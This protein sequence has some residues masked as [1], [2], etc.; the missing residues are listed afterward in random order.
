MPFMA[1]DTTLIATESYLVLIIWCIAALATFITI[2]HRD[3]T[4]RFGRSSVAWISLFVIIMILSVMWIR[5]MTRETTKEAYEN[6]VSRHAETC[7]DTAP[8]RA[9]N[10]QDED[11]WHAILWTNLS[12]VRKSIFRSNLVQTGLNLLALALMFGLYAILRRHRQP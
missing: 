3:S 10:G 11:D 1:F 2:F 9:G 6:I 12:N 5:Q 8:D 7:G 4:H